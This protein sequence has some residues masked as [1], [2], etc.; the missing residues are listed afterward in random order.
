MSEKYV[1]EIPN[2]PGEQKSIKTLDSSYCIRYL[3][4]IG[5]LQK[6]LD[7]A[8]AEGFK[9]GKEEKLEEQS[10]ENGSEDA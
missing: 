6:R 8:L 1:I 5:W 9:K 2:R 7:D 10:R 3:E 4:E